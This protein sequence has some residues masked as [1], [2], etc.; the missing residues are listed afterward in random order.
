MKLPLQI[1]T[2]GIIVFVTGDP[3]TSFCAATENG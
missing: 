2:N 3:W 1:W